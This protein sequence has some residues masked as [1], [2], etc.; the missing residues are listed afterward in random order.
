MGTGSSGITCHCIE[1]EKDQH[2]ADGLQRMEITA[3][4]EVRY[5][6]QRLVPQKRLQAN[7]Q[8]QITHYED[9]YEA[10]SVRARIV[11][12]F[13]NR[14]DQFFDVDDGGIDKRQSPRTRYHTPLVVQAAG[15]LCEMDDCGPCGALSAREED[16]RGTYH[17]G[18]VTDMS[19]ARK[20]ENSHDE[21][22]FEGV[23]EVGLQK[24]TGL[25]DM[26]ALSARSS[27][28]V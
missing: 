28:N 7:D 14:R 12:A 13:L 10:E 27:T 25:L 4:N 3:S 19:R 20:R 6:K 5:D 23:G 16:A 21:I 2:E 9:P 22:Q 17:G 15:L 26:I 18:P 24:E 8:T 11:P 1:D